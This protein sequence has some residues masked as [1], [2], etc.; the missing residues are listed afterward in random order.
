MIG[1]GGHE[2]FLFFYLVLSVFSTSYL[3]NTADLYNQSKTKKFKQKVHQICIKGP[4][5][6][7]KFYLMEFEFMLNSIK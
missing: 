6:L 7:S 2:S 1:W 4:L 3:I 5:L